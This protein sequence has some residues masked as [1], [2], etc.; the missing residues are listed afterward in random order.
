MIHLEINN[1]IEMTE[2]A[3]HQQRAN[4]SITEILQ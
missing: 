2:A 4:F 1:I 3:A